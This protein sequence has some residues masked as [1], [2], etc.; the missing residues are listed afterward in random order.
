MSH[1]E[2]DIEQ[3]AKTSLTTEEAKASLLLESARLTAVSADGHTYTFLDH[4]PYACMSS[5]W[6]IPLIGLGTW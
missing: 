2:P 3:C 5:G 1:P 4:Q 6:R